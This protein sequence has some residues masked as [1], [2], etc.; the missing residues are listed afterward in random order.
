MLTWRPTKAGKQISEVGVMFSDSDI[1]R[2]CNRFERRGIDEC[3]PWSYHAG[4]AGHGRMWADGRNTLASHIALALDGRPRIGRAAALHACDNPACV[5]PT[6]LRWG[7]Q[8]E[9]I[10]DRVARGRNGSAR[11]ERSATAKLTEADVRAIRADHRVSRS[12]A[13]DYP[14]SQVMISN[15]KSRRAW[16]HVD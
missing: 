3:W 7:S 9:N 12:I 1:A 2:F 14:V 11:G 6:H 16:S 8:L 15:I 10:Q 13:R 5:N 4:H